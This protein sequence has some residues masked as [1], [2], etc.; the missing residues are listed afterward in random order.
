MVI[1][2]AVSS[3][4]SADC[5]TATGGAVGAGAGAAIGAVTGYGAG[6]GALI[7]TGVGAAGGAI[8]TLPDEEQQRMKAAMEKKWLRVSGG[9]NRWGYFPGWDCAGPEQA[10][11]L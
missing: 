4:T 10:G 2:L 8:T 7:G 11:R 3:L 1:A 9:I 6:K 5:G